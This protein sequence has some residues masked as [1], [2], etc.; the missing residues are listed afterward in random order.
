MLALFTDA[1]GRCAVIAQSTAEREQIL[2]DLH[3]SLRKRKRDRQN[4]NC[5]LKT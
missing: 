1:A 2:R 3:V 5:L 4:T